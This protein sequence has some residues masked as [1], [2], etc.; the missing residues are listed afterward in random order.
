M[1][2]QKFHRDS[3]VCPCHNDVSVQCRFHKFTCAQPQARP[4]CDRIKHLYAAAT[5]A[6]AAAS[7]LSLWVANSPAVATATALARRR[8]LEIFSVAII[9]LEYKEWMYV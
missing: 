6:A 9:L 5:V 4:A 2:F 1:G 8:Q 7:F 3:D